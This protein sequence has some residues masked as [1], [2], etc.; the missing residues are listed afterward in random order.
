MAIETLRQLQDAL[1]HY[2]IDADYCSSKGYSL[3]QVVSSLKEDILSHQPTIFSDESYIR[4]IEVIN[5]LTTN[6]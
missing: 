4:D 1:S 2:I 6:N 3:Q 5:K